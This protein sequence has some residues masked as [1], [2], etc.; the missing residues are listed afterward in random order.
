MLGSDT[1]VFRYNS[2]EYF[3]GLICFCLYNPDTS[4]KLNFGRHNPEI[5]KVM[6]EQEYYSGENALDFA[7]CKNVDVYSLQK[8]WNDTTH[9]GSEVK[10]QIAEDIY[11]LDVGRWLLVRQVDEGKKCFESQSS[12]PLTHIFLLSIAIFPEE[13]INRFQL[14]HMLCILVVF[15]LI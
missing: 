1:R 15:I 12:V 10:D 11:T 7:Q 2:C 5:A 3:I 8:Y 14:L 6:I 13:L 4:R 9:C